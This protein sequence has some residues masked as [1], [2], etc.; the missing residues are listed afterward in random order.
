[1]FVSKWSHEITTHHAQITAK[2]LIKTSSLQMKQ[3]ER[4]RF[5]KKSS[6]ASITNLELEKFLICLMQISD[7]HLL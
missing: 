3:L 6:T 7:V 2:T 4:I 5:M 1:M